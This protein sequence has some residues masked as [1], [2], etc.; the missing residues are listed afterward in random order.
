MDRTG[1]IPTGF[2]CDVLRI[3]QSGSD[4][5]PTGSGSCRC[6]AKTGEKRSPQGVLIVPGCVSCSSPIFDCNDMGSPIGFP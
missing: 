1:R 4:G 2:Q 6:R 3:R 5:I